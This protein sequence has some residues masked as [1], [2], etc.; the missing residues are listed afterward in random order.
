MG[1][2]RDTGRWTVVDVTNLSTGYCPDVT[3]WP[4]VARALERAGLGH[5]GGFTHAV[6]LRR[7]T[8]CREF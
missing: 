7:C 5:P 4:A 8:A 6:V 2:G 1:F 3:C